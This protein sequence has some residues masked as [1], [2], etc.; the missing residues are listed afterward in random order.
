M[1]RKRLCTPTVHLHVRGADIGRRRVICLRC[2]S[3]PRA[4]SRLV[5]AV[6]CVMPRRFI[7][8]CVEQTPAAAASSMRRTGSSPRAW[9]RRETAARVVVG[10]RFISTCVEQTSGIAAIPCAISV[11][12]HVRGADGAPRA[13]DAAHGGSSPRAWSR[14]DHQVFLESEFRFIST[15]VEQTG[16]S[17]F[18]GIGIPVH[19]HVRGA[20]LTDW[21]SWMRFHG[22][23]PRAWSRLGRYGI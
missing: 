11:H 22:S 13:R 21:E 3:S 10:V 6:S 19:L 23:S 15:C 20:D 18:S 17:S 16:S 8:T 1:A 4:W 12:L 7:S 5:C 2:G 9:S 14:Q